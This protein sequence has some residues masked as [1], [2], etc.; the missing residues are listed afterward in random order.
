MNSGVAVAMMLEQRVADVS[1]ATL[2]N[3]GWSDIK[4]THHVFVGRPLYAESTVLAAQ[5]SASRPCTEITTV[6]T[7]WLN[8]HEDECISW[9]R[10]VVHH[11]DTSHDKGYF[12]AAKTGPFTLDIEAS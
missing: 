10:G 9:V 8:Q 5:P 7:R 11:R 6:R 2:L 12:P 1:Q 4:L 3:L